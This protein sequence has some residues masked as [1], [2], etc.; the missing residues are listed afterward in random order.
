[1]TST[2]LLLDNNLKTFDIRNFI[3]KLTPTKEKNRYIC[4]VCEGNNLTIDQKTGKYKCWNGCECRDI[5]EVVSPWERS[6]GAGGAGVAGGEEKRRSRSSSGRKELVKNNSFS[7]KASSAYPSPPSPRTSSASSASPA[8]PASSPPSAQLPQAS[9]LP[10]KEPVPIPPDATLVRLA[11]PAT[12]CPQPEPPSFIPK[13]VK[14]QVAATK[15]NLASVVETV[16][17][18][19]ANQQVKRFDWPDNSNPKGHNK[20]FVQCH[21]GVDGSWQYVKGDAP[22]SAYRL[23]EALAA[24]KN[25]PQRAALLWQEGEKCVEI[26]RTHQI[27]SCTFSG[28]NWSE[29]EIKRILSQVKAELTI[30]VMV[31][32]YDP[33]PTGMKKAETFQKCC[34]DVGLPCVLINPKH[35][36][37]N[38]PHDA[39]DRR[40]QREQGEQ[41]EKNPCHQSETSDNLAEEA[42]TLSS[43]ASRASSAPPAFFGDIEQIL[44]QMD[45]PDFIRKLEEQIH[46][47]VDGQTEFDQR[48]EDANNFLADLPDDQAPL[49]EITQKAFDIL[50]GDKPWICALDKL[51]FWDDIYYKHSPD[52]VELKRIA[53]FCNSYAVLQGNQ[54]RFPYANPA[55]V[56]KI[57][58]WVK[59]LVGVRPDALNPPG[60]NCVNG[61][62]QVIWSDK[63]PSW[64]LIE[65]TP[66]LYYTY[67]P[68]ALYDPN[69]DSTHC[70]RLLSCLDPAQT[71]I[72]LRTIAASLDLPTVRQHK[73]RLIKGL[74]CRG[75]G[76]N[77]KDTL[78]EVVSLM[79][80]KQGMTGCTL[81]DF[82][83]Y[84]EG[85]KFPLAKLRHSRV[86]WATENTNSNRLDKIQS[87]KAFITGTGE[88]L[89]AERKGVDSEEFSPNA[90]ALFNVND[91]PNIQGTLEA[92]KSRYA[93]LC[94]NKT[95]VINADPSKGEIEADSR[96]KYDPIFVQTMVVPAFLNRVLQALVDLM[97]DGI[98]YNPTESALAAIQTE[99]CHLFQFCQ[100]VGLDYNPKSILTA[101]EIWTVLEQWYRD[102]G[103]LDYE[104]TSNGKFKAT[105]VEQ[106]K[107]SDKNVKA[108]NQV[109]PRFL[110]LFP[111]AKKLTMPHPSGKKTVLAIQGIGF[112]VGSPPP[113]GTSFSI[114]AF[115][116]PISTPSTPI[117]PQLPPQKTTLN[118]DF[119]PNHPNFSFT[120]EEKIKNEEGRSN[121]SEGNSILADL[122]PMNKS[123]ADVLNPCSLQSQQ[124]AENC[125]PSASCLLPPAPD[126]NL[127]VNSTALGWV[128][129][130][131]QKSSILGVKTGVET[132]VAD[133]LIGVQTSL[134]E[135]EATSANGVALAQTQPMPVINKGTRVRV[136]PHT[137]GTKRDG[138]EG[139]VIRVKTEHCE[140]QILTKYIVWLDD[141]S[142]EPSLRQIECYLSWLIVLHS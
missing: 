9:P 42:S 115:P 110:Q 94:F 100:D 82:A 35:I 107:P 131:A 43:P 124:R 62:L 58:R 138:K 14:R 80:G 92:I 142:L 108:P 136:R 60:I 63:V 86:N 46:A 15:V 101:S 127:E 54:I 135:N 34:I 73:G 20:T 106:A 97:Q 26:A 91:T 4:P 12:D 71:E 126:Q 117:P 98:D 2:G 16:Y 128:G 112:N 113:E 56:E 8:A 22:W 25:T 116:T 74:L 83:A 61:V 87:L 111:K 120:I 11:A 90:I 133:S 53:N 114:S 52:V 141:A 85:R 81:A 75:D 103:T 109:I 44:A 36:C 84:D 89:D 41:G 38:L 28:S 93:V 55:A 64:H 5:R 78:R 57:L 1:M 47:A 50:Y 40:E 95:F 30:A 77:G 6:G 139:V 27:A 37:E 51:Y 118:Q 140:G 130:D 70:D 99:N 76:N 137:L 129:C 65:H 125:I 121:K 49:T 134:I 79:Y 59:I 88:P 3:E 119:H 23:D 32:L 104:E 33:D 67:K 7:S 66:D 72:F 24:A 69:A 123:S 68:I 132:G 45:V 96:F 122:K 13:R 29:A 17:K 21:M 48:V 18:Y 10:K 105:W 102:N 39:S 31:F 19:S